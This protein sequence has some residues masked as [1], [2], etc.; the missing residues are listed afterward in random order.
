MSYEFVSENDEAKYEILCCIFLSE[1]AI[2]IFSALAFNISQTEYFF[3]NQHYLVHYVA[4]FC[5]SFNELM[6]T[7][8]FWFLNN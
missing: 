8:I 6:K 4:V 7:R 1:R 2:L 3:I 5:Y